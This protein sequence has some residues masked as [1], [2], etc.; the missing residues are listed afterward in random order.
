MTWYY[1]KKILKMLPEKWLE[2][3]D[4][5]GKVAGHKISIQKYVSFLYTNS[6]LSERE[7]KETIPFTTSSKRK[8]T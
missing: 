2:L 1:T 4:E 6:E 7:I 5:F 3:I 8:I